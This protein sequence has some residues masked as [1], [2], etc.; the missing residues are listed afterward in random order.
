LLGESELDYVRVNPRLRTGDL[1]VTPRGLTVFDRISQFHA[2][3]FQAMRRL[4]RAKGLVSELDEREVDANFA[5]END[6]YEAL[7]LEL[8]APN[9]NVIPT[10]SIYV[11]DT[12]YLLALADQV[13]D[14][15]ASPSDLAT[16]SVVDGDGDAVLEEQLELEED[17]PSWARPAAER[18]PVRFQ[19][20]VSLVDKWSMP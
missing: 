8:R 12:E 13:D 4:N 3:G 1:H 9:G 5:A 17:H 20:Y 14:D 18:E 10:D 11:R 2:D 19:L 7:D 6:H 16:D 15:D